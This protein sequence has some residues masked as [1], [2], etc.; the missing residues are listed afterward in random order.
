MA[1]W[2]IL[3]LMLYVVWY[4]YKFYKGFKTDFSKAY[5]EAQDGGL[6]RLR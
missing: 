2:L 3:V 6:A 4:C 5:R 1:T